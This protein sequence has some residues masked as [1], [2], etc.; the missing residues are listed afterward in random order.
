[1]DK[2]FFIRFSGDKHFY[3]VLTF[4]IIFFA[5]HIR[6]WQTENIVHRPG[7]LMDDHFSSIILYNVKVI[8]LSP[9][10]QLLDSFPVDK[11]SLTWGASFQ[12]ATNTF[13][14]L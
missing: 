9:F 11:T 4:L 3:K 5:M 7:V 10:L 2:G 8:A 13:G 6:N 1:M 14:W 12:S